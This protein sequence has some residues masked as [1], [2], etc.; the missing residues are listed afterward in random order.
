LIL[1]LKGNQDLDSQTWETG[2]ISGEGTTQAKPQRHKS[3]F[4][5]PSGKV[6]YCTMP[7]PAGHRP[8]KAD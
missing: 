2:S 5:G 1:R 8:C 3:S 6:R 7:S 4:P